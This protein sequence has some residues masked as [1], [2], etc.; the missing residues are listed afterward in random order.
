MKKLADSSG[1]ALLLCLLMISTLCLIGV[2]AL[3]ISG[4]NRQIVI[5]AAKKAKAFYVAEAGRE[6]ALARLRHDPLWRGDE[7]TAPSSSRGVLDIGGI[8]GSYVVTLSDRTADENGLFN[9]LLPAGYVEAACIGT[10]LDAVQTV[11]CLVHMIPDEASPAAFPPKAVISAGSVAGPMIVLDEFGAEKN[12][13]LQSGS[14]LPEA[15]ITTLKVLAEAAFSSLDDDVYDRALAGIGSFWQDPPADTRPHIVYVRGDLDISGDRQLYGIY[16]VEGAHVVLSG[17]ACAHGVIYA[18]NAESISV[19]NSGA[20][21]RQVVSGLLVAGSGGVRVTGNQV[22]V[23]LHQDY[24][25]AFNDV[26]G[27]HM[28][29]EMAPGSWASF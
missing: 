6:M 3:S 11:S 26:A 24:V 7:E 10:Y 17:A 5:N 16:F 23:Q 13:L 9:K 28:D 18:P 22:A 14:A 2:A 12:T 4:L 19:Q 8:R 21:G 27:P 1:M 15:N 20:V 29:I 25:D